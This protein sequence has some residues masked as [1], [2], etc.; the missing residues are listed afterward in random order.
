MLQEF[1]QEPFDTS[2]P[3]R[4]VSLLSQAALKGLDLGF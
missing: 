2:D 4:C 1:F 3:L